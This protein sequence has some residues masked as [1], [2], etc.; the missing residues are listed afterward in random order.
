M[1]SDSEM[2]IEEG[3]RGRWFGSGYL[4]AVLEAE[5]LHRLLGAVDGDDWM[6]HCYTSCLEFDSKTRRKNR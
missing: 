6:K 3:G 5:E 4:A 2:S 1:V